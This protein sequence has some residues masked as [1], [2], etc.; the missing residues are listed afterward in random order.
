MTPAHSD[1]LWRTLAAV[2]G[3]Y[4]VANTVP[5]ALIAGWGLAHVDAALV[6]L[7]LSF[8]FYAGAVMWAFGA[9]SVRAAWMGI[10]VVVVPASIVV[11]A[12]T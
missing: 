6:A 5:V 12:V 9:R 2:A 11:W 3:G 4:A 8:L 1:V 10:M 7:Q